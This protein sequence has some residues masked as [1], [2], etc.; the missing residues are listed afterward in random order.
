MPGS[1]RKRGKDKWQLVVTL[2][3]EYTGKQK[4][5]FRTFHGSARDADKAL[6]IFYAECVSGKADVGSADT[7]S[8]LVRSY[9]YNRPAGSL[10]QNTITGYD[11]ILR[12]RIDP[13][14]GHI[15]VSKAQPRMLQQ[16]VADLSV[17]LSPKT[18]RNTV[19]LLSAAFGQ[20]YKM[21]EITENPCARLI[22]PRKEKQEAD[23]Y[24]SDEVPAFISALAA[25]PPEE[26][27]YKVAFELALFCGLRKGEILGLDWQDVDLRDCTVTIR[28]TRYIRR[29]D[30]PKT[31]TS[32]R[33]VSF[34]S[35]IRQDFVQLRKLYSDMKV[36]LGDE[37][38]D[39]HAVIQGPFGGPMYHAS[40]LH[41]L[42]KLQDQHGLRR[43]TLHQLRHTNVTIMISL[44]LDIKTIQQRGGYS[45]ATTPLEIYGHVF[46]QKDREIAEKLFEKASDLTHDLTH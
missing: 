26:I 24:T 18:I 34:P 7:I 27:A 41:H 36:A 13:Y 37:W 1:K 45:N 32:C 25:L 29:V 9:I 20:A 8:Q 31:K 3:T 21:G 12:L 33:T 16:W 35:D 2:G 30:T 22:L 10:K 17:E 43:I 42:H 28:Q 11:Q 6:A 38:T 4:R 5:Y 39:S 40:L 44:G 46:E 19:G 23:Y 14:I 15:K